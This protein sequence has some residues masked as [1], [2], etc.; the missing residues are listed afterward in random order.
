MT[1]MPPPTP[2]KE[3]KP[4]PRE[5]VS[6]PPETTN[7][8]SFSSQSVHESPK[9]I[10]IKSQIDKVKKQKHQ[11]QAAQSFEVIRPIATFFNQ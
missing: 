1:L 6:T 4:L 3:T 2:V 5:V 11:K 7:D 10:S 9:I 8:S